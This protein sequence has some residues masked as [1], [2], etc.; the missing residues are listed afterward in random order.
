VRNSNTLRT[1]NSWNSYALK[2]K[3][4]QA[5]KAL[6]QKMQKELK[7]RGIKGSTLNKSV[8]VTPTVI[9]QRVVQNLTTQALL[10]IGSQQVSTQALRP[11]PGDATVAGTV[12]LL[13]LLGVVLKGVTGFAC[14][15][16]A[17][18]TGPGAIAA[19]AGC[20]AVTP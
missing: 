7:G 20:A 1:W 4:T 2:G 17:S 3:L 19:G 11:T 5:D 14:G 12:G 15:A 9:G 13:G 10:D 6:K 16:L 18:E 8:A